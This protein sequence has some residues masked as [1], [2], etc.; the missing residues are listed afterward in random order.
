M[1]MAFLLSYNVQHYLNKKY[2]CS[3]TLH[4]KTLGMRGVEV[5]VVCQSV[6][7]ECDVLRSSAVAAVLCAA[8]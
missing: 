2:E 6:S 5:M 7:N 4:K 1:V 8:V 3:N